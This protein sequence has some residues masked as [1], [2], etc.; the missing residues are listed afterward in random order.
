MDTFCGGPFPVITN[1]WAAVVDIG[2][3]TV[4]VALL[5]LAI[6]GAAR[7]VVRH[8]RLASLPAA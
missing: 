1:G 8:G 7:L 4:L 2:A 6:A 3:M 5:A